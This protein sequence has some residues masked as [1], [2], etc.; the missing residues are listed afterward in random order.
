MVEKIRR[1]G[2]AS[3][4]NRRNL[5]VGILLLAVSAAGIYSIIAANNRTEQF[6]VAA[7]PASSGSKLATSSLRVESLN[8]GS[9]SGL[10]LKPD[11]FRAGSYLL[12]TVDEGQLI[13]RA[14]VADAIIDARQPVIIASTMQVPKNI[15]VGDFVDIWTSDLQDNNKYAPPVTLVLNAEVSDIIQETEVL[16]GQQ[17]KLQLLVPV[18][19]V[20]P[21]LDAIASKDALSVVLKRSLGNE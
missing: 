13:P 9:S 16:G 20:A 14:S 18:A 11:Q 2:K 7:A 8:L 5:I 1:M 3:Q 17:L 10:Y 19:S 15:K 12:S 6:L 21:I 4:T